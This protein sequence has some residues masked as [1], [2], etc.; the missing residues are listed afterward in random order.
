MALAG[1]LQVNT[2]LE[3]LDLGETDLVLKHMYIQWGGV[4]TLWIFG[5]EG[6]PR[7]GVLWISS[8]RD[9]RM[10]GNIKT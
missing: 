9:D 1:A 5:G 2:M 8:D 3:E 7:E 10:G 4:G 6:G